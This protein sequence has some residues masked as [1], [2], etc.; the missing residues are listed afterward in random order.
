[1]GLAQSKFKPITERQVEY[2]QK[3][4]FLNTATESRNTMM[5]TH[6]G[7]TW[8]VDKGAD[9]SKITC[10]HCKR[11]LTMVKHGTLRYSEISYFCTSFKHEG[12][13]VIR[14]FQF[15]KHVKPGEVVFWHGEVGSKW[16]GEDG[17]D[18]DFHRPRPFMPR[19]IDSFNFNKDIKFQRKRNT[20]YGSI[21]SNC[22]PT[23]CITY[24]MLPILK[25]NGWNGK[26]LYCNIADTITLLLVNP[27]FES[28]YKLRQYGLCAA[29][30]KDSYVDNLNDPT[31]QRIL[32]ICNRHGRKF[33]T[34]DDW[35]DFRD[36]VKD[37]K[38]FKKDIFNIKYLLPKNF[39]EEHL[40]LSQM[41]KDDE[42]RARRE[43][44]REEMERKAKDQKLRAEWLKEYPVRFF[45]MCINKG[46]ITI[47]PLI[48]IDD[49][50]KE[51]DVM[52]HC[53][54]S[55]YGKPKTLLISIEYNGSKTE[56]AEIDLEHNNIIQ[57]RGFK[58]KS[59]QWHDEI[60][61]FI[62][63]QMMVFQKRYRKA[64]SIPQTTLPA[65]IVPNTLWVA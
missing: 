55:Y 17:K 61:N 46:A 40:K 39:M 65:V 42:N 23:A 1:M 15:T 9:V 45:D 34:Y 43:R 49:F 58:N 37:L 29:L 36:Y 28:W 57:C 7:H 26:G 25:R 24:S 10:P 16:I 50:Q 31:W 20:W 56:T 53:I 3:H 38:Y 59:S 12:Y 30:M 4:C 52:E 2:A 32:K 13:Q 8:K 11:K 48:T 63:S 54:A 47:K 27:V 22:F 60:V 41:R 44:E 33:I 21:L 18:Y 35:A 19:Y 6:C 14:Y 62:K 5:C 51:A 64:V